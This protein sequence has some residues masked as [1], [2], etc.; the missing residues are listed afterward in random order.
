VGIVEDSAHGD[1]ELLLAVSAAQHALPTADADYIRVTTLR[2]D[3]PICPSEGFQVGPALAIAVKTR[4]QFRKGHA[5]VGH[6]QPPKRK[7]PVPKKRKLKPTKKVIREIFPNEIVKELD[8]IVEEVDSDIP[9]ME[10]PHRKGAKPLK[11][12]GRKWSEGRKSE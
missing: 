9:R 4:Y 6:S 12:W 7:N 2:T 10:N 5:N 1:G 3:G 11:P 8:R